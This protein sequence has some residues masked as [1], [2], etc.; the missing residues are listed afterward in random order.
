MTEKDIQDWKDSLFPTNERRWIQIKAIDQ[1]WCWRNLSVASNAKENSEIGHK[2]EVHQITFR[3]EFKPQIKALA[4]IREQVLDL[5]RF[6]LDQYEMTAIREIF[7]RVED[8]L[9]KEGR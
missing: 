8:D 7:G 4:E 5:V 2:F 3:E 9:Y 6:R 1:D